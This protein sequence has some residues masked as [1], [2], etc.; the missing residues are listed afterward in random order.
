MGLWDNYT[1]SHAPSK[2]GR[3]PYKYKSPDLSVGTTFLQHL[4]LPHGELGIY[5]LDGFDHDRNHDKE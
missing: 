1:P 3:N 5:L 2:R 4:I